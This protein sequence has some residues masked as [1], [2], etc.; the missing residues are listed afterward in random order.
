MESVKKRPLSLGSHL[1]H[2]VCNQN[3]LPIEG[4]NKPP[5]PLQREG[6]SE[7]RPRG[8]WQFLGFPLRNAPPPSS[9]KRRKQRWHAP[10][11]LAQSAKFG[12][13]GDLLTFE[14]LPLGSARASADRNLTE[15]SFLEKERGW[16]GL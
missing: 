7:N 11:S 10:E 1:R 5:L 2:S 12:R 6:T 3:Q 16:M 8:D 9:A 14:V 13:G 15:H 4:G